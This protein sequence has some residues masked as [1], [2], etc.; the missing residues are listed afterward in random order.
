MR[1]T[2]EAKECKKLCD[3][4]LA[5]GDYSEADELSKKL[6]VTE[7]RLLSA[8]YEQ[9]TARRRIQ[10]L[11]G[12]QLAAELFKAHNMPHPSTLPVKFLTLSP[13]ATLGAFGAS[14]TTSTSAGSDHKE[15]L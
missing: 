5:E 2:D 8:L 13:A 10:E 7:R 3:Q 12:D 1:L 9:N 6:Q 4:A 15:A 11:D 14:S